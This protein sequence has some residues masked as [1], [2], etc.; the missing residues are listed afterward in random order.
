[1]DLIPQNMFTDKLVEGLKEAESYAKDKVGLCLGT[2]WKETE[3]F[4][5]VILTQQD[6]R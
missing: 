1:M 4:G 6:L 5:E 2:A 3:R